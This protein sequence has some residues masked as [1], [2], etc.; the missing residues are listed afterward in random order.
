M[1]ASF[2]QQDPSG[3]VLGQSTRNHTSCSTTTAEW[4]DLLAVARVLE[5]SFSIPD[6]IFVRLLLCQTSR[7]H[8]DFVTRNKR[9]TQQEAGYS[10]RSKKVDFPRIT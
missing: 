6:N 9:R 1:G 7:R 8:V 3:S 4:V 10:A 2:D 5:P